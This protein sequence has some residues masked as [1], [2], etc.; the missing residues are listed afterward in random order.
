M[1]GRNLVQ[2]R[3]DKEKKKGDIRNALNKWY[4]ICKILKAQDKLNE[5]NKRTIIIESKK[6]IKTEISEKDIEKEKENNLKKIKGFFK[7]M[8]GINDLTKKQAMDKVLPKLEDYLKDK[9]LKNKLLN[10]LNMC[11]SSL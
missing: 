7:L 6:E 5:D 4:Y 2:I 1:K 8:D 10:L 9:S 11:L 3:A